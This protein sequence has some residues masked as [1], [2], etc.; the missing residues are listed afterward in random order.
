M[1][2][3]TYLCVGSYLVFLGYEDQMQ[4]YWFVCCGTRL[5][6]VHADWCDRDLSGKRCPQTKSLKNNFFPVGDC[7]LSPPSLNRLE[8]LMFEIPLFPLYMAYIHQGG[9]FALARSPGPFVDS[10]DELWD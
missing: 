7:L 10:V 2:I 5:R 9:R 4:R 8:K 1:S 3:S 6:S